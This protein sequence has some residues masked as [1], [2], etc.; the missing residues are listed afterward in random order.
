MKSIGFAFNDFNFIV[1]SF[2]L[3]GVDGVITVVDDPALGP[4]ING[5]IVF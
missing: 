5:L 4:Y 3:T 2:Q 1:Y